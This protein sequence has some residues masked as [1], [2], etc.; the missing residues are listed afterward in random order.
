ME[1]K[2]RIS[3][4]FSFSLLPCLKSGWGGGGGMHKK[5]HTALNQSIFYFQM[6]L[7]DENVAEP[8]T[9]QEDTSPLADLGLNMFSR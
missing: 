1:K 6:S 9:P 5:F 4:D 8:I 3:N 2:V 7:I